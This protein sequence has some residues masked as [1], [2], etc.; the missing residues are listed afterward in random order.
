MH[1]KIKKTDYF[2]SIY[3]NKTE[4]AMKQTSALDCDNEL[5]RFLFWFYFIKMLQVMKNTINLKMRN[6]VVI[7]SKFVCK[8]TVTILKLLR[9]VILPVN[10]SKFNHF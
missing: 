6:S 9:T 3:E 7:L 5:S 4:A 8:Y 1:P 2:N 10:L